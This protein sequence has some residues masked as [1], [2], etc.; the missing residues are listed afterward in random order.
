[1]QINPFQFSIAIVSYFHRPVLSIPVRWK[2]RIIKM[3]GNMVHFRD[4]KVFWRGLAARRSLH[5][6]LYNGIGCFGLNCIKRKWP[7]LFCNLRGRF[8][9]R[10]QFY[11]W[12]SFA[13]NVFLVW[14]FRLFRPIS[15][16]WMDVDDRRRRSHSILA[17]HSA[18]LGD[19]QRRY[20]QT[21]IPFLENKLTW[22]AWFK[23]MT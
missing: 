19:C 2:I 9:Y 16:S 1:M 5:I 11:W 15:R 20:N 3:P 22:I 4:P 17:Y 14:S 12:S 8:D 21:L 6:I 18:C 23:L 7:W 10:R 13:G